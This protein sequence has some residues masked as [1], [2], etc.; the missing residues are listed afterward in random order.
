MTSPAKFRKD[1]EIVAE[2]ETQVKGKNPATSFDDSV[3]GCAVRSVLPVFPHW[4]GLAW[5]F[6]LSEQASWGARFSLERKKTK[7]KT[8]TAPVICGGL[9]DTTRTRRIDNVSIGRDRKRLNIPHG[10]SP[11]P[12]KR[13]HERSTQMANKGR[14]GGKKRAGIRGLP[15]TLGPLLWVHAGMKGV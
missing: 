6:C 10:V 7:K 8:R 1:K 2:Y 11:L 5:I 3:Y 4:A 13:A 12:P 14:K 15:R 9:I